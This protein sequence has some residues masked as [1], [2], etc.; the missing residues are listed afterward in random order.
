M[1]GACNNCGIILYKVSITVDSPKGSNDEKT[2]DLAWVLLNYY[3]SCYAFFASEF[4][5]LTLRLAAAILITNFYYKWLWFNL[6]RIV[7]PMIIIIL[8]WN[9][10]S[11]MKSFRKGFCLCYKISMSPSIFRRT[12]HNCKLIRIW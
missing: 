11:F 4:T 9:K 10:S 3:Y 6:T 1:Y 8:T 7:S 5:T 2:K 12:E